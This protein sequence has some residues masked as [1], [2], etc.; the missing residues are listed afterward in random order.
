MPDRMQTKNGY[1]KFWRLGAIEFGKQERWQVRAPRTRGLWA[2]PY[3]YYDEFFTHHKYIDLVPKRFR[4]ESLEKLYENE[5]WDAGEALY[6]EREEWIRTVARRILPIREFWYKGDVYTHFTPN[7][8]I[9][10]YGGEEDGF[11]YYWNVLDATRLAKFIRASGGDRTIV[12]SEE[13]LRSW[14]TSVDHLE[15]FIAPNMGTI[16]EGRHV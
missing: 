1:V 13:G 8:D 3:P 11:D 14:R 9:Q 4:D 6:K 10:V 2:F 5:D 16:R 7:G 12:R 15:V